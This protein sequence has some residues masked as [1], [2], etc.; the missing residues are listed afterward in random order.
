MTQRVLSWT[1]AG[2]VAERVRRLNGRSLRL[3]YEASS[4]SGRP[5]MG[6]PF[7]ARD[8]VVLAAGGCIEGVPPTPLPRCRGTADG[9]STTN[10]DG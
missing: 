6:R 5:H 8:T 9:T 4:L 3:R 7:L 2:V 10:L 1:P